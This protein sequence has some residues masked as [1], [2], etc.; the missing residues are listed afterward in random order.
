MMRKPLLFILL[1][2]CSFSLY[3]QIDIQPEKPRVDEAVQVTLAQPS[4]ML[5]VTYRPNSS[6]LRRDTLRSDAPAASF[7]WT[8]DRAGVVALSTKDASRNVSVRFRGFSWQGLLVMLIA[9]GIL[10]GGA[11][12]AFRMMFQDEEEDETMDYDSSPF[13]HPDT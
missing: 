6:V 12:F 13:R 10:F 7:A 1:G 2:V 8:P 5:V 9:A 3:A 4:D 11:G